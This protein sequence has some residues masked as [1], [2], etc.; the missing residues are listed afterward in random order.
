MKVT[1]IESFEVLLSLS[2]Y[3]AGVLLNVCYYVG[4]LPT[5]HRGI[6]EELGANLRKLDIDPIGEISKKSTLY[7]N[8]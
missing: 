5:G 4:G 7:F 3:E 8:S 2:R 6:F 1:K